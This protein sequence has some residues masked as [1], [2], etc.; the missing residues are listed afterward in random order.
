MLSFFPIMFASG[1]VSFN[2][3]LVTLI[4]CI[5]IYSFFL[6]YDGLWHWSVGV[7]MSC[8]MVVFYVCVGYVRYFSLIKKHS[9]IKAHIAHD[10]GFIFITLTVKSPGAVGDPVEME[11]PA[12]KVTGKAYRPYVLFIYMSLCRALTLYAR[13]LRSQG[14]TQ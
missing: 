14:A 11:L 4:D 1:R 10:D 2:R 9:L 5:I 3:L 8:V 6:T 13:R 12:K 7:V